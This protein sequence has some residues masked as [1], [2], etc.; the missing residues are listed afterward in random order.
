[1][2]ENPSS[3]RQKRWLL[4]TGLL[5]GIG[6]VVAA[7]GTLSYTSTDAFCTEACH[8]HPHA[9]DQ[10]LL[11]AHYANKRGIVTHCTDC[12]LPPGGM[13]YL[14][15]KARLGAHDAYGQIF[16]DIT[17]IDWAH[18]RKINQ[19]V[20]FTYDES[21]IHC[22]SNL[23]GQG[24]S[25][26]AGDLPSALQET[27]AHQVREMK[28]VARRMEAHLYYQ[29]NHDRLHCVNCHLFEGHLQQKKLL[30]EIAVAETPEFPLSPSGFQNYTEVVTG[31]NLKFHMIAVPAGTVEMGSP[32]LG[33][34]RQRDTGP[35]HEVRLN[36][37]WMAQATVSR[38]DLESFD[39]QHKLQAKSLKEPRASVGQPALTQ[40]SASSYADWLSRVTGKKYRLPTEAELE[41]ACIADGSM[42]S[43]NEADSRAVPHLENT[44]V[45]NA[46]GFADL[47]DASTE[48][49]LDYP[50]ISQGASYSDS[51]RISF[52]VV[53]ESDQAKQT[54]SASASSLHR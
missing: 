18:E 17:K 45:A 42:P 53:R 27:D 12:H 28:L 2:A 43:W 33:M 44:A 22:H 48:L 9:T 13:R 39:S 15:E 8:A 32:Q 49:S 25:Q 46:W 37:F 26:V 34:C 54:S 16:K 11:S 10:W 1:V 31:S 19:A 35:A 51:S 5:L 29:R 50:R 14:T 7:R 6:T 4:G 36:Q 52:R 21:C 24:L 3:A 41:Y 23:F 30:S 40:Q 20:T 38:S 47:P